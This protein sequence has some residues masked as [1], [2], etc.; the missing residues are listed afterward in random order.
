MKRATTIKDVQI[1]MVITAQAMPTVRGEY[2]ESG[3]G[4]YIKTY[5]KARAFSPLNYT[6]TKNSWKVKYMAGFRFNGWAIWSESNPGLIELGFDE[7]KSAAVGAVRSTA[8]G[9]IPF[10]SWVRKL[11]GA[12]R[13]TKRVATAIATGTVRR[14]FLK[15][16]RLSKGCH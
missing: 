10:R 15:G 9:L 16:V 11:T 5:C 4:A 1:K 3:I 13:Y 7:A 8:E 6:L 2:F 14:A 12:E